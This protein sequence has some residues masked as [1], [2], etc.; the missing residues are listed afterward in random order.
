MTDM[1]TIADKFFSAATAGDIDTLRSIYSP[2]AQIW[3]NFDNATQTVDENLQLLG[4]VSENWSNFR[5][6]DVRRH[7][8]PGG[9]IQQHTMRG[10]GPD[11]Q[12]FEAPAILLVR[13][14]DGQITGIEEYFDTGQVPLPQ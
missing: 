12:P 11:G 2:D 3:H 9:L 1:H 7:D 4:W 6:E 10:E 8:I 5:F 14:A 13:I